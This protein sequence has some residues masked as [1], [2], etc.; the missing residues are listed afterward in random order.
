[1][2]YDDQNA[3]W[4]DPIAMFKTAYF[5]AHGFIL[6]NLKDDIRTTAPIN[7]CGQGV[8]SWW[9]D[10]FGGFAISD[11]ADFLAIHTDLKGPDPVDVFARTL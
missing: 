6:F 11:L 1:M 2:Q 4:H 3:Q 7:G 10:K 9:D 8:M 5:E